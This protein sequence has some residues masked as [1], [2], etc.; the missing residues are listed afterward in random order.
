M[1]SCY[2]R[3]RA[4]NP[5][6]TETVN[7]HPI[8]LTSLL[9]QTL[10]ITQHL[11]STIL[12][13]SIF[14]RLSS[15]QLEPTTLL[16]LSLGMELLCRWLAPTNTSTGT[17]LIPTFT[18]YLLSPALKTLTKATTSD[19]IWA[20]AGLLFA[21]NLLLGDY[22]SIPLTTASLGIGRTTTSTLPLTAALLASTVLA[23]R[24]RSNLSVF[25]LLLFSTTFFGP[26]PL[27]R[28]SLPLRPSILLTLVLCLISL[29]SLRPVAGSGVTVVAGL[30][31]VGVSVVVPLGRGWLG[32]R[33]KDRVRGPWDQAVPRTG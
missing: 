7:L 23:S 14:L 21:V 19:S 18:L 27:L 11:A 17:G 30:L 1:R 12:F 29:V 15:A 4:D 6:R 26:F 3:T 2:T 5:P 8:P 10:P 16:G 28:S 32:L 13:L 33:W 20:F 9:I 25:S 22:R 24:L 31:M